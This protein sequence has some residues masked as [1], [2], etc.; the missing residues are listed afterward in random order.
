MSR[1]LLNDARVAKRISDDFVPASAGI[2]RVQPDRYGWDESAVSRWFVPMAK[3]AFAKFAPKGWWEEFKTYQGIYVV[4]ADGTTYA[5]RVVWELPPEELL[6]TL[7]AAHAEFAKKPPAKIEL[8]A[9]SVRSADFHLLDPST[10]AV[11][12]FSRVRPVPDGAPEGNRGVGRDHFWVFAPE[13]K[14]ILDAGGEAGAS[15]AMPSR[16]AARL[17]RFTLLDHV[18]NI[19]HPYDESQ[20]KRADFPMWLKSRTDERRSFAFIGTFLSERDDP[21]NGEQGKTGV[22]GTIEGEFEVDVKTAKIV[23]WRAFASG[24]AWGQTDTSP[25]KGKYP[26]VWAMVEADD[27][28]ARAVPPVWYGLSPVWKKIYLRPSLARDPK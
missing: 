7:D 24:H 8:T 23:R 4:G 5:Y 2:E 10:S 15:V 1:G 9:D 21:E 27:A 26:M 3:D 18:R 22:E 12:V 25:P 11:R 28:T 16:I 17:V 19:G 14:E 20:V 6:K 13:V